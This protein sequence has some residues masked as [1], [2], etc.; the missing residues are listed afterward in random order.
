M[1]AYFKGLPISGPRG[2][3]GP[4]GNPVG[5]VISYMGAAAPKDY[6][7]CDGAEYQIADYPELAAF[8]R[9]QFGSANH[10]GGDG[11]AAFAVPDL[12]DSGAALSCI[13][14]AESVPAENV[15]ST[16][17]TRIGT[18]ID[19]KP[20]Y[21]AVYTLE[22]AALSNVI[23]LKDP[24]ITPV[25]CSGMLNVGGSLFAPSNYV[26]GSAY[27][28]KVYVNLPNGIFAY[29]PQVYTGG[30]AWFELLYTKNTD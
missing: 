9:E 11:E 8:F 29:V 21:R 18:W 17:E 3:A 20:L 12:R 28:F 1:N 30:S 2:P 23:P 22:N 25:K 27:Y 14:A 5:T 15:Y 6:L 26:D 4:D 10:F 16:E 19:G 13:K 7:A 24:N